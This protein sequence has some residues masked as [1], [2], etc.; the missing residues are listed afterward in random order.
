MEEER[1]MVKPKGVGRPKKTD[2]KDSMTVEELLAKAGSMYKVAKILGISKV[3]CY[4]WAKTNKIPS[5]RVKSLML[6]KP[7]WFVKTEN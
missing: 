7:D 5:N 2:D 1:K 4:K 3:A 6:L